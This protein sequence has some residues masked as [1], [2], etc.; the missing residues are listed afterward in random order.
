MSRYD[1]VLTAFAGD[2]WALHK[3]TFDTAVAILLR[4]AAGGPRPTDLELETR[5]GPPREHAAEQR[6]DP[7]TDDYYRERFDM[8]G[9]PMGYRSSRGN[10]PLRTKSGLIAI[11]PVRGLISHRASML[12]DMSGTG[13]STET[14]SKQLR[15]ALADEA[16]S[17]IVLDVDSPGGGVYGLAEL[18]DELR[19]AR[20]GS[21]PIEAVANA[22]A[23]SAAYWI[24]SQ[25][26]R[27]SVTTSGEVGSVGV[28][29][30][31][32]NL[33]EALKNEG[34][35]VTAISHGANKL[36]GN[37]WEPL[38]DEARKEW[39]GRI[40]EAG[41]DFERNLH[42]GRGL[43]IDQVRSTFGEGL[44]F[45]GKEAVKR[46]MADDV[47]TLDAVVRRLGGRKKPPARDESQEAAASSGRHHL[48]A[49][50]GVL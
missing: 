48:L 29:A 50:G 8:D 6:Y 42:L 1:R 2:L 17:A 32:E 5:I 22:R 16:V 7:V 20:G 31:H 34:I 39:Q 3:P 10:E 27:L 36:L 38:S 45:R 40:D 12:E 25:T 26:D 30:L 35:E 15:G 19:K 18:S 9:A 14:V 43:P 44:V 23:F 33:A 47:A 13:T 28:F 49:A 4:R 46:G 24:A 41:A 11:I 21:K 37:S